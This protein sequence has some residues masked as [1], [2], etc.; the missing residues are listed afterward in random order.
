[1]RSGADDRAGVAGRV[2]LAD[3]HAVGADLDREI[4]PV[5]EDEQR[6]GLVGGAAERAARARRM[7]SSSSARSRS[8]ITS[9][10]PR[11]A[12]R[13]KSRRRRRLA[14]RYRRASASAPGTLRRSV[15]AV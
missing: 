12:R 2:V 4:R 3:M 5:V 14:D 6:A 9:T 1:M 8:W 7:P 13:S 11:S 10:P 15:A